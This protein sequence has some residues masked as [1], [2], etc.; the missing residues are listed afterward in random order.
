MRPCV[1][2]I[3]MAVHHVGF[4][5]ASFGAYVYGRDPLANIH[6]S[7][8]PEIPVLS[9]KPHP[10]NPNSSHRNVLGLRYPSKWR[11]VRPWGAARTR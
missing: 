2:G 1:G 5:V 7:A 8:Q 9:L 4:L 10:S 3:D 6:F 11:S